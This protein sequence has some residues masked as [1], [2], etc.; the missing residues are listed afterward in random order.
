MSTSDRLRLPTPPPWVLWIIVTIALV[1]AI[2]Q[3][4]AQEVRLSPIMCIY[5]A[6]QIAQAKEIALVR[7][8]KGLTPLYV[9]LNPNNGPSTAAV[10]A[11]FLSWQP[12]PMKDKDG[13]LV[14]AV[15]NAGYVDLDDANGRLK[16][17][18]SIRADVLT[19][20]KTGV[21]LVFL[22][23]CHA[24]DIQ[25]QA[26]KLRDVIW[27]A[28]AGTGY[29]TRNVILNPGGPVTKA[30]SWM[31]AKSYTV[32]DFEDPVARLKSASTGQ[33]WLS[34]VPDRAGAQQLIN[35]ALQRKT[36]RLIGFDRLTNW[37]VAGKEWQTTLPDDIATLLK[38]L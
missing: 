25:A 10:R 21:P 24:W 34:F 14:P 30:S 6:S 23:D 8:A 22:D 37:K 38:N 31:R 19:W 1:C 15:M 20:R 12:K 4:R 26:N 27:S 11:P 9:V 13:K 7:R 3:C 28:I 16:P 29:E 18:A 5:D 32:C 35:V 36:V 33:M 2:A 17:L